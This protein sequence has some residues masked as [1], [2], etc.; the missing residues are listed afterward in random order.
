[1]NNQAVDI[2]KMKCF[3]LE[4]LSKGE[5]PEKEKLH[6]DSTGD[7]QLENNLLN[8]WYQN[9][10]T[11]CFLDFS[12]PHLEEI[13]IHSPTHIVY[14]TS[15]DK[16]NMDSDI[17]QEDLQAAFEIMSLRQGIAWNYKNPFASFDLTH[18]NLRLRVTLCHFSLSPDKYSKC[19]IRILNS[20]TIPLHFFSQTHDLDFLK[21]FMG[22]KKNILI[23]GGTGSGKT[24][25]IN[26]LLQHIDQEDHLIILEDVNEITPPTQNT[27]K[28]LADNSKSEKS[29][30]A[31]MS[32]ALRMSP[33][34]IVIG[35]IRAKEV[36]SYLLAM[37]TG[38]NGLLSTVHANSAK[39]AIERIAL[40][41]KIYSNQDLS[42]ELVLKLVCNNIDTVIFLENKIVKEVINLFGSEKEQ[43]FYESLI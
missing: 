36:E 4:S 3:F 40:L 8:H 18:L 2:N 20:K 43:I 30:N 28:L 32:Y 6:F 31:Y 38:H 19:F 37:N 41:F 9:I 7:H 5:I 26:S 14:K 25:Y 1:M 35:E 16:K 11:L 34:R 13:F 27:T 33:D 39:D 24:T 22:Q 42:Y 23:A 29:L 12:I 10:T 15:F 21:S 17:T